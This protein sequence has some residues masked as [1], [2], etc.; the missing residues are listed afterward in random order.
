[1]ADALEIARK[2]LPKAEKASDAAYRRDH[3]REHYPEH[4]AFIVDVVD[5]LPG[6][7]LVAFHSP[8]LKWE[9][10]GILKGE[11]VRP[12]LDHRKQK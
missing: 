10:E 5:A 1:M 8:T 4:Y 9:R 12:S 7:R 3:I 2:H 11:G 6:S